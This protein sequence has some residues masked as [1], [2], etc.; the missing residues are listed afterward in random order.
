MPRVC[1]EVGRHAANA[2]QFE[3]RRRF[4]FSMADLALLAG[5]PVTGPQFSGT[6]SGALTPSLW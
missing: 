5:H 2:L 4:G 6:E 1:H 3:R